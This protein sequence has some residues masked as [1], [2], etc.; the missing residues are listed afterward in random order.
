MIAAIYFKMSF[1]S[2][3]PAIWKE[4]LDLQ[5]LQKQK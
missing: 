5:K 4:Y 2:L 1:G 3:V